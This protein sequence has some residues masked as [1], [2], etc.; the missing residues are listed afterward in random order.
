[1]A[2][3][4]VWFKSLVFGSERSK[5]SIQGHVSRQET[6]SANHLFLV[7]SNPVEDMVVCT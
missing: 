3:A 2:R 5:T 1:M 6:A 4:R 7:D